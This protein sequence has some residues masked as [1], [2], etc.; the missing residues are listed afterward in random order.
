MTKEELEARFPEFVGQPFGPP[1]VGHDAVNEPMI[2]HWCE[3]M[4]D[5]NPAYVDPAAAK[6]SRHGS[7]VAP[8]TMMQAWTMA[9]Y[10]M[11]AG[12]DEPRDQQEA[13]HKLFNEA[14][15][16]GV[17]ATD[18]KQHYA[19]YLR[20]GDVVTAEATIES[21]SEEKA[22]ALGIG[23]FV[24][25]KT[26]FSDQ[27]GEEVGSMVFRVLKFKPPQQPQRP[28]ADGGAPPK[29]G[30]IRAPRSFDNRWWW[31]GVDAGHLLIQKCS[32]CGVLRHPPR[33][34]CHACLSTEWESI[35][36]SG[37]GTVNSWVVLHHPPIP[38]Y[39]LPVAIAVIDLE[40]GTR[41]VA[42]IV[43]CPF[44]EIAIDM[45]VECSIEEIE[46]GYMLP[47]FRRIA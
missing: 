20:P 47:V 3:T 16:T 42:N 13:L 17:V 32:E 8:P 11:H 29:P 19:R 9:G 27:D 41:I 39:E 18:C 37:Q 33:P 4:G 21:I 36:S 35:E 28:A 26:I 1:E 46:E 5:A 15:Y 30:R 14:G 2:R 23:Y 45:P 22:T 12:Y 40:E 43:D 25:T 7:I 44:E 38:G 34:M 10:P 31:D 6:S 24:E